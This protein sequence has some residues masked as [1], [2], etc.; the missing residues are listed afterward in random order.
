M[1][2]F[3]NKP[4]RLYYSIRKLFFLGTEIVYIAAFLSKVIHY[5]GYTI[6]NF[7]CAW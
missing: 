6:E 3:Q 5:F 4:I 1:L 2:I 7:I